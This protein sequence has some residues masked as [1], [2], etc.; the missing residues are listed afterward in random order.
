MV[1]GD[2]WIANLTRISDSSIQCGCKIVI[3]VSNS[4]F[5]Q[6]S[7]LVHIVPLTSR[8]KRWS[9]THVSIFRNRGI[10]KSSRALVEQTR[11]VPQSSLIRK[12]GELT[13]SDMERVEKALLIQF[14]LFDRYIKKS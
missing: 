7:G 3:V 14:G 8:E 4:Q 10:T 6:Y 9:P 12:I 11:L 5:N 1:K 2:L 13:Y